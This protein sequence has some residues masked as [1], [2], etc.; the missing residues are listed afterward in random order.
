M[1]SLLEDEEKKA[2]NYSSVNVYG[3]LS[4]MNTNLNT[5]KLTINFQEEDENALKQSCNKAQVNKPP[6]NNYHMNN[7]KDLTNKE[8]FLS[9]K[10]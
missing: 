4:N 2:H 1:K 7:L 6:I 5:K 10:I 9:G 8:N 3:T